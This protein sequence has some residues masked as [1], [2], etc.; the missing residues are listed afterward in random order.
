METLGNCSLV[1]SLPPPPLKSGPGQLFQLRQSSRRYLETSY[2]DRAQLRM[3]AE[4][5]F[6]LSYS[7]RGSNT[8]A[9]AE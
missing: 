7:N 1:L 9:F 4:P 6:L 2:D 5:L 8:N 3:S